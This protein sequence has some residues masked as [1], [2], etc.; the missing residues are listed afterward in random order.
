MLKIRFYSDSTFTKTRVAY[1]NEI[2]GNFEPEEMDDET[3][4]SIYA[5]AVPMVNFTDTEDI[6]YGIPWVFIIE[7]SEETLDI[8][9]PPRMD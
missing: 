4:R 3:R 7:I 5:G 2:W 8:Y 1:A 6:T 9:E